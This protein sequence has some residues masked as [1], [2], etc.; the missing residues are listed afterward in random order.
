L[1]G[2]IVHVPAL[3]LPLVE[4]LAGVARCAVPRSPATGP[5]NERR[6]VRVVAAAWSWV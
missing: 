1:D 4:V 5:V 3:K 6:S 2:V